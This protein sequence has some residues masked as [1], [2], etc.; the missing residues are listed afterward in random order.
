[1]ELP[2]ARASST[3]WLN[4]NSN[5]NDN[6]NMLFDNDDDEDMHLDQLTEDDMNSQEVKTPSDNN[7]S[8]KLENT[9]DTLDESGDIFMNS[10][11]DTAEKEV[12]AF[13]NSENDSMGLFDSIE[14]ENK[15][16]SQAD[17]LQSDI[18]A[19]DVSEDNS[20][21]TMLLDEYQ[22]QPSHT[23]DIETLESTSSTTPSLFERIRHF[24]TDSIHSGMQSSNQADTDMVET[25]G[26]TSNRVQAYT[27]TYFV[28][29]LFLLACVIGYTASID[30]RMC[31]CANNFRKPVILI[32]GGIVMV[33]CLLAMVLPQLFNWIPFLK[34]FLMTLTFVVLYCIITYFPLLRNSYCECSEQDWRRWVVEGIVYITIALFVLTLL[35]IV[36]M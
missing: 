11:E 10:S 8:Q 20:L 13:N 24:F 29:K 17:D 19:N 22:D 21:D 5:Y 30:T 4:D 34:A 31:P 3:D 7:G 2:K 6:D 27:I 23:E 26:Y 14:N 18:H 15:D 9:A 16:V 12:N 32:G 33:L 35:G 1:M 25:I 28:I 36:S